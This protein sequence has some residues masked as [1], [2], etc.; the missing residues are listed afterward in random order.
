[1]TQFLGPSSA[2]DLAWTAYV[3]LGT[4]VLVAV[5]I[6]VLGQLRRRHAGDDPR[7]GAKVTVAILFSLALGLGGFLA[8]ASF[9]ASADA[10]MR[11]TFIEALRSGV[12]EGEYQEM[13]ASAQKK[14]AETLPALER[15]LAQANAT[16]AESGNATNLEARNTLWSGV[17]QT[18][19]DIADAQTRVRALAA[20]HAVWLKVE[21]LLLAGR[22]AEARAI[23]E[24]AMTAERVAQH[25]PPDVACARDP[26]GNCVQPMQV[27]GIAYVSK[28]AHLHDVELP[29]AVEAAYH[30]LEEFQHQMDGQLRYLV[31]PGVTGL[32]LAPFAFAG[33]SILR[34]AYVPSDSVGFRPYPGQ[35]AGWFLLLGAFGVFAIPFGAWVLRDLGRRS[36]EGQIAL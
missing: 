23:L 36:A 11:S 31:Y 14:S 19:K 12:G 5:G 6:K 27:A 15:R 21:P 2:V 16:L 30:H 32:F 25:V 20:N 8:I 1:M 17:N 4:V 10:G 24:D 35:A 3:V 33:G 7:A 29:V 22:D 34:R 13:V 28:D 18:R 26:Q 9:Q